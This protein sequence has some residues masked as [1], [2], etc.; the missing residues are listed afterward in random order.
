M[1]RLKVLFITPWYPTE[2]RPVFCIFIRE[3]AKSVFLNNDVI[4]MHLQGYDKQVKGLYEYKEKTEE[5]IRAITIKFGNKRFP[6]PI[7]RYT[8]TTIL[9]FRRLVI[10]Q[11]FKPDVIHAHIHSVGLIAVI[12]G[13]IYRI[14]VIITEHW[15]GFIRHKLTNKEKKIARFAMN[16]VKAVLPV[17]DNLRRHIESYG[18]R[19]NF[20]V[21]PN[22]VNTKIFYPLPIP[23]HRENKKKRILLVALLTPVKGIPY[24][25][26][27]LNQ[28][29]EK[30]ED[31]VLD[32]VG[33]GF[34]RNEYEKMTA[35]LGLD[36]IVKFH[37]LKFKEEVAGFMQQCDFFVLPSLF[38]TFGVVLIEALAT[39]KPVIATDIGGP[40]EIVS[41]EVGL[42]V[43]PKDVK[44]LSETIDY[45]LDHYQDYSPIKIAQYAKDRFS[46]ETVGKKLDDIYIS[47]TRENAI[48]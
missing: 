13:K 45:M 40:N 7:F 47:I 31:F 32:I 12:L 6:F 37:G 42:I 46:Y 17:S 10:K 18:I 23:T 4:V 30:R 3:H 36:D 16:R 43:P 34:N 8:L 20:C 44:A 27:A 5:G 24:L 22:V 2:D 21:V 14:P 25:L 48:S 38:E 19:N 26:K 11:G 35:D 9:A 28:I 15:S 33:D 41:Q 39:G 29:R 1:N